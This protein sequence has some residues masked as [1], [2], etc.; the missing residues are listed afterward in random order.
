ML[1][2][3]L[4]WLYPPRCGLCGRIGEPPVCSECLAEMPPCGSFT[5]QVPLLDRTWVRFEYK[6][7]AAQAVR[8]LKFDR[9]TSLGP[10]LSE[11]L[12]SQVRG[13]LE[14]FDA[15]IPVPIHMLRRIERGFNQAETLTKSWPCPVEPS[16]LRRT[17]RTRPQVGLSQAERL[18]NLEGA[19]KAGEVEGMRILLVDDVIT[20]GATMTACADALLQSRAKTVS[21]AALC[22][23][24]L[25]P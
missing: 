21:A 22:G 18:T 12:L 10:T 8:R 20:S 25:R 2:Q 23:E 5:K 3:A 16:L 17:K 4:D 1:G 6:A 7:R 24:L 9:V 19:F 15:V 13:V 11:I 14:D